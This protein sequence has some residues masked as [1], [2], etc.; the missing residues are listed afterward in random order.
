M[1]NERLT[2]AIALGSFHTS[3]LTMLL[4]VPLYLFGDL[5]SLLDDFSTLLGLAAFGA[6]WATSVY[7]TYRGID[8]AGLEAGKQ[9]PADAVM[10]AGETW[11]A[12]NGMWFFW[13]LLSA[14]TVAILWNTDSPDQ[15]LGV[16]VFVMAAFVIGS[17][18]AALIG[19]FFGFMFSLLELGLL[20]L[21]RSIAG[22][23]VV[24][25]KV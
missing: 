8:A 22:V 15:L 21:A 4:V 5:G 23:Q 2:L 6:L 11:G 16:A 18:F 19:G 1:D 10:R 3:L 13:C 9:A 24:R 25:D 12:W 14:G 7:A 20:R 17:V